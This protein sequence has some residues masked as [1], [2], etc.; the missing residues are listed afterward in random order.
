MKHQTYNMSPRIYICLV[1]YLVIVLL[2]LKLFS[3][4]GRKTDGVDV[5][6]EPGDQKTICGAG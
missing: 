4:A 6:S 3:R 1:F 2:V 5:N